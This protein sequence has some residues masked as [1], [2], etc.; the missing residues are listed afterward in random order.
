[1]SGGEKGTTLLEVLVAFVILA[2]AMILSL[3]VFA[4]G[5]KGLELA[6]ERSAMAAVARREIA[7]L[8]LQP[9]LLAGDSAGNDDQ[10]FAWSIE[11]TPQEKSRGDTVVPFRV[12]VAVGRASTPGAYPVSAE[13]ILLAIPQR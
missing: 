13:T 5:L 11:I 3:R 6:E 8:E 10:G 2:G 7:R 9:R 1:M 4:D 12:K